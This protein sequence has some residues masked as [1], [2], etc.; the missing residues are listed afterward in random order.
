M[1]IALGAAPAGRDGKGEAIL[2]IAPRERNM[3]RA[4]E[5]A[6]AAGHRTDEPAV[7]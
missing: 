4:I 5:R 3:L 1:S 2:F 7:G 6:Y